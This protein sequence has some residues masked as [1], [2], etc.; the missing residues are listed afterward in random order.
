MELKIQDYLKEKYKMINYYMNIQIN[1]KNA[2]HAILL[3]INQN[4]LYIVIL[5]D[6]VVKG[7]III[8]H[9]L[10]NVLEKKIYGFLMGLL[11]LCFRILAILFLL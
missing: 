4:I 11:F 6:V 7:M 3:S 2:L 9:G 10:Q 5:V 8:V 1:M